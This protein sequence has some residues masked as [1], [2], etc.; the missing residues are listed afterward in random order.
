MKMQIK[1]IF[2]HCVSLPPFRSGNN[3]NA[4]NQK[5]ADFSTG[6]TIKLTNYQTTKLLHLLRCFQYLIHETIFHGLFGVEVVIAVQVA[7]DDLKRL[8][9]VLGHHVV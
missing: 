3:Y 8:A 9:G 6:S 7:L 5:P 1:Q 4:L 2:F